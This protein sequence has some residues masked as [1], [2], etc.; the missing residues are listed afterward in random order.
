MIIN[1]AIQKLLSEWKQDADTFR[2]YGD[3]TRSTLLDS[4]THKLEEAL[5]SEAEEVLNLTQAAARSGLTADYLGKLVKR[6]KIPNLGRKGA[7][8]VRVSDLPRSASVQSS[9]PTLHI[10]RAETYRIVTRA[11]VAN[12]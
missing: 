5:H 2:R 12:S 6:G 1:P 4:L 8:R 11:V 3:D 7:P 9:S 10:D